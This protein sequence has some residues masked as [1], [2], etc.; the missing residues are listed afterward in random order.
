MSAGYQNENIC[1]DC[2]KFVFYFEDRVS[3]LFSREARSK[4]NCHLISVRKYLLYR[5]KLVTLKNGVENDM[6]ELVGEFKNN[7]RTLF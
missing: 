4:V 6:F 1:S 3:L 2:G 5:E 7:A